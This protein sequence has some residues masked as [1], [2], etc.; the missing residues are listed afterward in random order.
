LGY[1]VLRAAAESLG[2][3][4]AAQTFG[5][6]FFGNGTALSGVVEHPARLKDAEALKRFRQSWQEIYA[7]PD[8]AHKIAILEEGA[9]YAKIGVPPEEAQFIETRY[10]QTEEITRWFRMPPHKI[11]HLLR[12]TDNN[13]E[14]QD[15]EYTTDA[16]MSWYVR[17][18]Q[19]VHWKLLGGADELLAE[20]V[21]NALMRGDM[22]ARSAYYSK[23]WGIGA[24]SQNDIRELDNMNPIGPDGDVYYVPVNMQPT[25]VAVK[26]PQPKP[27]E[28]TT[29]PMEPMNDE[30]EM[31]E[32]D[33]ERRRQSAKVAMMPVFVAAAE[34]AIRKECNAMERLFKKHPTPSD[35][36]RTDVEKFYAGFVDD[37]VDGMLPP[38]VALAKLLAIDATSQA[39]VETIEG[40]LRIEA[41][42]L[43]GQ[44]LAMNETNICDAATPGDRMAVIDN[45]TTTHPSLWAIGFSEEVENVYRQTIG[46]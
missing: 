24:L 3:A 5:A 30:E 11:Q 12:S 28:A 27:Q 40:R 45:I 32:K 18:E 15:I 42:T 25:E 1:S 6:T 4:L 44:L 16:L 8:N 17:W 10:F 23:Q 31:P 39:Q 26:G 35:S 41:G 37:L 46:R 14:H 2:L 34:R 7:G 36:C 13:I 43:G 29:Q 22:A 19:E 33:R 21:V 38:M 9:K 20:H